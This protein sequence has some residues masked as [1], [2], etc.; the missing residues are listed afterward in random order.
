LFHP[1]DLRFKMDGIL[2]SFA[3]NLLG[4]QVVWT[5]RF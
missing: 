5:T 4:L 2:S 3:T 1:K